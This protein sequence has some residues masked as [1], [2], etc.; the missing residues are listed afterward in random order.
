MELPMSRRSVRSG[1]SDPIAFFESLRPARQACVD[2]LR[3][4]GPSGAEHHM[5]FVI[6]SAIDVAAEFFTKRRSFYFSGNSDMIG[7]NAGR[8]A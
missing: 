3:N 1:L 6:I 8:D 2:Q 4:L 5:M 7:W